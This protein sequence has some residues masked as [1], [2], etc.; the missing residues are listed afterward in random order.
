MTTSFRKRAG[1]L[2][3]ITTLSLMLWAPALTLAAR[4]SSR[5]CGWEMDC[6]I[7]HYHV[8]VDELYSVGTM[9]MCRNGDSGDTTWCNF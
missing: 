5:S 3:V 9:W 4:G 6:Y 1:R 8:F 7:C 2:A